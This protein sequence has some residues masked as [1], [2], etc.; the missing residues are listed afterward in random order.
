MQYVLMFNQKNWYI[1]CAFLAVQRAAHCAVNY[2]KKPELEFEALLS[3][4][5][6]Q[7]S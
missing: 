4:S 7:P 3:Q 5:T 2:D 1:E 6:C